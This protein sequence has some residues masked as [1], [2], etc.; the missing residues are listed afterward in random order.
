MHDQAEPRTSAI[1]ALI[2]GSG[3]RPEVVGLHDGS[4]GLRIG[5]LVDMEI[6]QGR[7]TM[8]RDPCMVVIRSE[9]SKTRRQYF[10]FIGGFAASIIIKYPTTGWS[11][12]N[13]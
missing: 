2:S 5:D 12:A 10:T 1:I 6:T 9:L 8:A 13:S 4:D 7:I 11:A 3:V